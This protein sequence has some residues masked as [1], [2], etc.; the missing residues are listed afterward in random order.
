GAEEWDPGRRFRVRGPRGRQGGEEGRDD[1]PSH[2]SDARARTSRASLAG[3][4]YTD[5]SRIR[6]GPRR[7]IR[8]SAAPSV[9][10][11]PRSHVVLIRMNP[12]VGHEYVALPTD[13]RPR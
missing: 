10:G 4:R 5:E 12:V 2:R 11:E 13:H 9:H 8:S 3:M 7:A 1:E 6:N